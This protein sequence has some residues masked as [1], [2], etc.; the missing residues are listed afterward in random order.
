[1]LHTIPFPDQSQVAVFLYVRD[2]RDIRARN[3]PRHPECPISCQEEI[4]IPDAVISGREKGILS[5]DGTCNRTAQECNDSKIEDQ[6]NKHENAG[7]NRGNV[8]G[9]LV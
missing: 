4:R 6:D 7:T 8:P 3:R 5:L 9:K 1:V 2:S